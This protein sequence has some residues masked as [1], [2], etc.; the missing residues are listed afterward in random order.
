LI[1]AIVQ[2]LLALIFRSAGKLLNTA[3]GWATA[4]LFGKVPED[5]QVYLSAIAF[6]SVAWLVALLGIIFPAVG[7]FLLAFVPLPDWIDRA[8]VRLAMLAA[9]IVIPLVVGVLSLLMLDPE[10]RPRGAAKAKAVVKGYPYTLGLALTLLLMTVFAPIIK[11][12]H[13]LKRWT[14][15]HVPVI[16]EPNDYLEVVGDLQRALAAGGLETERRPASWLLRGP[17]SSRCWPAARSR[18]SSRTS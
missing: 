7:T 15:A 17:R 18:S 11:A 14:S 5:R 13:L 8:W 16:I 1:V 3:F 12:R 2:G 4:M 9:A 6:G 10:D